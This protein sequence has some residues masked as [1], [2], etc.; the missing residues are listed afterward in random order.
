M[1]GDGLF[2]SPFPSETRRRQVS[3]RRTACGAHDAGARVS[4][5]DRTV[6]RL[7]SETGVSL[8]QARALLADAERK[9]GVANPYA[10]ARKWAQTRRATEVALSP[11]P[12]VS[13]PKPNPVR[14]FSIED[15]EPIPKE[16][17]AA[18]FASL[19]R[20]TPAAGI[21]ELVRLYDCTV[22]RTSHNKRWCVMWGRGDES[23]RTGFHVEHEDA[24]A[25]YARRFP[26]EC[27]RAYVENLI[28]RAIATGNTRLPLHEVLEVWRRFGHES[29]LEFHDSAVRARVCVNAGA[30]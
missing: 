17:W 29:A 13:R 23:R 30:V 16:A 11:P 28:A 1:R 24:M 14:D 5:D 6:S 7:A 25:E 20:T 21:G 26:F 12:S 19:E 3:A 10:V 2:L 18:L 22:F 8:D 27:P 9:P 4:Y 15:R